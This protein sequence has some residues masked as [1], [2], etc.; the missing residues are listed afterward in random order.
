MR[1]DLIARAHAD[2]DEQRVRDEALLESERVRL[3]GEL[4]AYTG[5]TAVGLAE[6]LVVGNLDR[7]AHDR[8]IDSFID[9][10]AEKNSAR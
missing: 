6:H 2:V 10:V 3:L 9:Q 4:R 5:S 8:L 7:S 1:D